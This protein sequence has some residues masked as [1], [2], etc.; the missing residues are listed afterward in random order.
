MFA[1]ALSTPPPDT[2][3]QKAAE[4]VSRSYYELNDSAR[5]D[6]EPLWWIVL[7]WLLRPFIWLFQSLEGWPE[8]VR[9]TIVVV[10]FLVLLALVAHI[11]YTFVS[12]IRGP[13]ARR[14]R[15]YVS[16]AVEVD[17][18]SLEREA[19][20]ARSLGDFIGAVRLL[21]RAA[22]TR[23]EAAE[24]RRLRPGATN[25]EVLRR[26]RSTP[27]FGSLERF[28][29]TIDNKWYGNGECLEVDYVTCRGEHRRICEY[30]EQSRATVPT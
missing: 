15:A 4:V 5:S 11:I 13:A 23:V 9:W 10:A 25:R 6:A 14:K 19:E 16:A 18:E 20:R 7:R 30:A 21:F 8:F 26:Y 29:E 17:P 22:L 2:I 24:K 1:A 3:R 28:V 12:A 27:I